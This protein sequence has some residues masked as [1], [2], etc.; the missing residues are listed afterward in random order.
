MKNKNKI[1]AVVFVFLLLVILDIV[2]GSSVFLAVFFNKTGSSKDTVSFED[3]AVIQKALGSIDSLEKIKLEKEN[4]PPEAVKN[5]FK[6]KITN[7]SGVP[8][9]AQKLKDQIEKQSEQ[10]KVISLDNL[11]ENPV[12]LVKIKKNVAIGIEELILETVRID[13]PEVKKEILDDGF[14][15]DVIIILGK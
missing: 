1:I 4:L 6:I 14:L 15:E 3:L 8:G 2:L 13:Y 12:T 7:A 5:E 11:K 9:A 10:F